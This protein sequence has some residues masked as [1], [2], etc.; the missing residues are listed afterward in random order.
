ML[1]RI[2]IVLVGVGFVAYRVALALE[3][4]K[5]R[6][7]GDRRREEQLRS[8]GFGLYRWA[9]VGLLIFTLVLSLLVWSSSR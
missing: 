5:A 9:A 8:R 4:R 7:S 2:V 6:R 3:I 1:W